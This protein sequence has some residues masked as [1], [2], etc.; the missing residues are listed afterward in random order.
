MIAIYIYIYLVEKGLDEGMEWRFG[1]FCTLL[2][3]LQ[4]G[5]ATVE[6][7]LHKKLRV[8]IWPRISTTRY[9][10]KRNKNTCSK[11]ILCTNI[12]GSIILSSQKV[13]TTQMTINWWMNKISINKWN[14][15]QNVVYSHRRILFGHT[16]EWSTDMS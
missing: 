11:K 10:P 8:I 14:N 4:N 1:Y 12:H 2:M 5:T 7:N 15:R 16:K 3:G 6:N 9:L 13:E